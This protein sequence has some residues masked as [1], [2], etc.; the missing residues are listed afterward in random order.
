RRIAR[1]MAR[2]N[3]RHRARLRGGG[4]RGTGRRRL[5]PRGDRLA[6]VV[7]AVD[8]RR[9]RDTKL[10]GGTAMEHRR[11]GT[12]GL[13]VSIIGLGCMGMSDFYGTP[14]QRD[15]REAIAAIRRAAERGITMLDTA[16]M[17]GPLTNEDVG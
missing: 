6:R 4:R 7:S 3:R 8:Y 16:D 14:D 9:D 1:R 13:D 2:A 15:N 11:L 5:R 12:Q 10:N 17:Y